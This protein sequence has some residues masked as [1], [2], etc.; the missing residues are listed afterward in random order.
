VGRV[1]RQ[2]V[3]HSVDSDTFALADIQS[4]VETRI[5]AELNQIKPVSGQVGV[6]CTI[7]DRVVGLDLFDKPTTLGRYL[8]GIVA[9]HALDAPPSVRNFDAILTIERFLAQIDSAARD[10]G[11]GVGLG[12]EIFLHGDVTGVGLTYEERLIHLAAFITP[13]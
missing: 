7:G 1:E 13:A 2:S 9:G 8:K 3:N 10:T 6:V 4:E 11:E 12:E 5:E